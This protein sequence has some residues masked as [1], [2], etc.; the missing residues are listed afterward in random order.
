MSV[1]ASVNLEKQ[2]GDQIKCEIEIICEKEPQNKS[3]DS[4]CHGTYN[5]G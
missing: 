1:K 4:E 2:E 5:G 3:N